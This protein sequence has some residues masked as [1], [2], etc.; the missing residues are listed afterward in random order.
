ML[1]AQ[2]VDIWDDLLD[3]QLFI[4]SP[5]VLTLFTDNFDYK[6][7]SEFIKGVLINEEV[8]F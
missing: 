5:T 8:A 7:I 2:P 4:C 6:T 3:C 1:V